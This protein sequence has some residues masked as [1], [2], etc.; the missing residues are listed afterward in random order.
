MRDG[1]HD[2]VVELARLCGAL[3]LSQGAPELKAQDVLVDKR[4]ASNSQ[5][6]V[7]AST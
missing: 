2:P 1:E 6:G 7:A 3:I 4:T 5:L